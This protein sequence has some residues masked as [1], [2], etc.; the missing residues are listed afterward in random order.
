MYDILRCKAQRTRAKARGDNGDIQPSL[1]AVLFAVVAFVP[2]SN[3]LVK[4]RS[5]YV[6]LS[7][8]HSQ[9][10]G[11]REQV[12]ESIW[13]HA[14]LLVLGVQHFIFHNEIVYVKP[15]ILNGICQRLSASVKAERLI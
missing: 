15:P 10:E 12:R 5:R 9:S 13:E 14:D 2:I 3:G 6:L 8:F 11:S 4:V 1:I 7:C